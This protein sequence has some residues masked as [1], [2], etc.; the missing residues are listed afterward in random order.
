VRRIEVLAQHG[1]EQAELLNAAR[2][3]K[4][5]DLVP[6]NRDGKL[7]ESFG[8]IQAPKLP[9]RAPIASPGLPPASTLVPNGNG[10]KRRARRCLPA[11]LQIAVEGGLN[12]EELLGRPKRVSGVEASPSRC[13][14]DGAR[15]RGK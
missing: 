3:A 1:T 11:L 9:R 6:G 4:L 5:R 15:S 13:A 8:L 12:V 2:T 14:G 10:P 7:R